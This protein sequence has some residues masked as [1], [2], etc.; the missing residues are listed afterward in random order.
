[1]QRAKQEN[2]LRLEMVELGTHWLQVGMAAE[3]DDL[4]GFYREM[5]MSMTYQEAETSSRSQGSRLS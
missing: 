5:E 2:C 3:L 1:M 4:Y